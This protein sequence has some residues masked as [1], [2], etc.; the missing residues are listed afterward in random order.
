ML[1]ALA[2]WSSFR[3][4][5]N[6]WDW[7]RDAYSREELR[8]LVSEAT[9]CS[10]IEIYNPLDNATMGLSRFGWET[11]RSTVKSL[12]KRYGSEIWSCCL[13]AGGYYPDEGKVGISCL[14]KLDLASQVHDQ[15]TFEEFLV[16]NALKRAAQQ[17]IER[18]G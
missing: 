14:S 10:L 7:V 1:E 11:R 6:F 3:R 12:M 8:R 15:K 13:G 4:N 18:Q 17:I 5:P 2:R 9:D 16:R